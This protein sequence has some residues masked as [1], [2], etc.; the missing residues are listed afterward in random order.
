[1]VKS[2]HVYSIIMVTLK[3]FKK[4]V[5]NNKDHIPFAFIKNIRNVKNPLGWKFI[6]IQIKSNVTD[7]LYNSIFRWW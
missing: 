3:T 4:A 1:M 6:V 5:Y 7:I 2:C